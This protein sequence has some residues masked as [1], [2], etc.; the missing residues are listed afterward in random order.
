MILPLVLVII[1][2]VISMS[3]VYA[4]KVAEQKA[5][6]NGAVYIAR[7]SDDPS[8]PEKKADPFNGVDKITPGVLTDP[9]YWSTDSSDP[10]RAKAF[11]V[12]IDVAKAQKTLRPAWLGN[13]VDDINSV[14]PGAKNNPE[15]ST[16]PDVAN[17]PAGFYSVMSIEVRYCYRLKN[18]PGWNELAGLWGTKSKNGALLEERAVAARLAAEY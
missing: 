12:A 14:C 17:N 2:I 8:A 11:A 9:D 10:R 4:I 1:F 6:Y 18:I 7:L 3:M 13:F 5:T 16:G 15:V